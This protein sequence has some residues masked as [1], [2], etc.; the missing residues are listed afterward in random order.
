MTGRVRWFEPERGFG[1]IEPDDG[2]GDVY[3][4]FCCIAVDGGSSFPGS[5]AAARALEPGEK[6]QFDVIEAPYGRQAA[7]VR[8]VEP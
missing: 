3:V 8:R 5:F 6:V 4:H 1:F 2:S 7:Q